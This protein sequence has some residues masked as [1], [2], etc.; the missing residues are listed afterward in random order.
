MLTGTRLTQHFLAIRFV[1][2][3]GGHI[4]WIPIDTTDPLYPCEIL[5]CRPNRILTRTV[6]DYGCRFRP[7]RVSRTLSGLTMTGAMELQ[8]DDGPRTSLGI[9]LG[10]DD[11]VG[12]RREFAKRF[13]ERIEKLVGNMPGDLQKKTIGFIA[14]MPEAIGLVGVRSRISLIGH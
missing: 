13:T 2:A 3:T 5:P 14:I 12:P 7:R 10:S 11:T 4:T 9:R 1:G 6:V 8:P